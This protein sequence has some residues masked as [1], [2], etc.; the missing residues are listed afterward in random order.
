MGGGSSLFSF[1]HSKSECMERLEKDG[2]KIMRTWD[3][4]KCSSC[5]VKG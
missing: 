2:Y 4:S 5:G 3:G 1:G